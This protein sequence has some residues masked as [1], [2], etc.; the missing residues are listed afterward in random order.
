MPPAADMS[1]VTDSP[2][3]KHPDGPLVLRDGILIE[4]AKEKEIDVR[5]KPNGGKFMKQHGNEAAAGHDDVHIVDIERPL[6]AGMAERQRQ[7]RQRLPIS[8]RFLTRLQHTAK[9]LH[10]RLLLQ[11]HSADDDG[12][13]GFVFFALINKAYAEMTL[14]W[15]CNLYALPSLSPPLSSKND[16]RNSTI[17]KP[18]V[19]K[20]A[21]ETKGGT[22]NKQRKMMN[23]TDV[24]E[25]DS[26][27]NLLHAAVL[28][29][30]PDDGELCRQLRKSWPKITC[31]ALWE[32]QL[33]GSGGNVLPA[34]G[35]EQ[36]KALSE[37]LS[38]G[39]LRYVQILTARA[40]LM[41]ALAE[42][43]VPFMVVES[44]AIWLR[45]P[46]G[47][48]QRTNMLEDA[49]LVMPLNSANTAKG[50][51]FAFDP[52]VA[53]A[54]NGSRRLLQEMRRVLNTEPDMMDQDL[55]NQLCSQQYA[56]AVC[57]EFSPDE[58]A[59]GA[60]LKLSEME[61]T[62]AAQQAGHWPFVVNNNYYVGVHNKMARQAINGLWFLSTKQKQCNLAKAKR[63]LTKFQASPTS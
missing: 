46:I 19:A 16:G 42:A 34:M 32:E 56:G 59:D 47:L 37:P 52:M 62:R 18:I 40:N 50:Q 57:R 39:R 27:N 30:T 60:W 35:T 2:R 48:F 7:R 53:F 5:K 29:V 38:W 63:I 24:Q 28:L 25:K 26:M 20:S 49:D 14:N 22:N 6:Q 1:H 12:N 45:N 11:R 36:L 15:L 54:T 33:T 17:I 61:R 58:I 41:A 10:R 13:D 4:E 21:N 3:K 43:K 9:Q 31:L 44:D 8:E 55:L 51:R 23:G